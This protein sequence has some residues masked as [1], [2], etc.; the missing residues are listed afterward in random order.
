MRR[1]YGQFPTT[2]MLLCGNS[3]YD[4]WNLLEEPTG[5]SVAAMHLETQSEMSEQQLAVCSE[6]VNYIILITKLLSPVLLA[7]WERIVVSGLRCVLLQD[8]RIINI[9]NFDS[10]PRAL[11]LTNYRIVF[12]GRPTNPFCEYSILEN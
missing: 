11:F 3:R 10:N 8:G 4:M 1:Q 9:D 2:D 6:E 7:P 12:K 5:M